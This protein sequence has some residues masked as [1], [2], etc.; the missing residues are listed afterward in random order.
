MSKIDNKL[1][2]TLDEPLLSVIVPVYGVEQY[3]KECLESIQKQ[4]YHNIE[5]IVI[6]DGTKD[7]SAIIAKKLANQDGRIRVYDFENGGLSVARNRGLKIAKGK[8]IA[9]IDSDDKI[10]PNMYKEMVTYLEKYNTD[11]VKCGFVEFYEDSIKSFTYDKSEI[12]KKKLFDKYFDG[13]LWTVV[14][15]AVYKADLAKKV[16][17]P[18][19]ITHED[20][21]SSGMYLYLAKT[22]GII[23]KEYYWYRC[24]LQG[25]SK[26]N[27]KK[28]IDKILAIDKLINNL[29][30]Y[31]DIDKRL[32]W[33]IS[34]EYYHFIRNNDFRFKVK[35]IRKSLYEFLMTHLDFRRKINLM[36]IIRKKGI[37]IL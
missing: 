28:P 22:V 34:V 10:A 3:I 27:I 30:N 31:K 1:E 14:W 18:E 2:E 35:C 36:F 9:F 29:K 23:N 15:N 21:Y 4:T 32:Y 5:I 8:Y 7:N 33:K 24:N 6:N 37:K 13:I 20:N 12:L 16:L 26:G 17:F 19:N 25:I 11:F